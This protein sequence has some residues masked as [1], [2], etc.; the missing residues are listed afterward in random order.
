[1]G[2][3]AQVKENS[4]VDLDQVTPDDL[5]RFGM[6]PEF[7]GRFPTWVALQDLSLDDLMAILTQV[8]HSYVEQYQWLFSRDQVD[9]EF[10]E[11]ALKQIATNTMSNRTGARGLHSELE[12]VLMPHMFNLTRYREQ[13]I[14]TLM[15]DQDLVNTPTE[16][17]DADGKITRK[18]SASQ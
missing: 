13:G 3:Q 6:I 17:K 12:R 4:S 8:R 10:T 18:L 11:Q 14:T 2:F 1:M 9:L 16:L 7:V 15:I 5:M